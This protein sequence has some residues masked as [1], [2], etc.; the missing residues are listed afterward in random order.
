MLT[1]TKEQF[2]QDIINEF[3]ESREEAEASYRD[4]L[5]PHCG[6][7]IDTEDIADRCYHC[8]KEVAFATGGGESGYCL[9]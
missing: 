9:P 2:I 3:G 6:K 4:A 5:C 1:R 7:L 8:G